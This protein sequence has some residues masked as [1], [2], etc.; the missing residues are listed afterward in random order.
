MA[1]DRAKLKTEYQRI[2]VWET[3]SSTSLKSAD[4]AD[5]STGNLK[6][7]DK[8]AMVWQAVSNTM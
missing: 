2:A 8:H 3:V 1:A 5:A 4:S 7:S 6:A